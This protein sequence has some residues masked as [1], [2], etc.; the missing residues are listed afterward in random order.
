M[1]QN[2]QMGLLILTDTS[3]ILAAFKRNAEPLSPETSAASFVGTG[4][5][6]RPAEILNLPGYDSL[7]F[8][9]PPPK[10]TFQ[11]ASLDDDVLNQPW[12]YYLDATPSL[13]NCATTNVAKIP[14]V[15]GQATVTINIAS[16]PATPVE[17]VVVAQPWASG[18]TQYKS[19][20]YASPSTVVDLSGLPSGNYHVLAFVTGYEATLGEITV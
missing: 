18:A 1:S 13:Q 19:S 15:A 9:I 11:E 3:H 4:L 5:H 20:P 8:T 6:L 7:D 17:I 16:A 12:N 2:P 10:L 14:T